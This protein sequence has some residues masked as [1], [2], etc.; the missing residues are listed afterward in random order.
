MAVVWHVLLSL[1]WVW[2]GL[3]GWKTIPA[4]Y[5]GACFICALNHAVKLCEE[6]GK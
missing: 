5:V 6:I 1:F 4:V 3:Y 2:T